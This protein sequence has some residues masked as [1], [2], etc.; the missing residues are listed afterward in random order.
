MSSS[1]LAR[2]IETFPVTRQTQRELCEV[3]VSEIASDEGSPILHN[4]AASQDN[5]L[6][7]AITELSDSDV[8]AFLCAAALGPSFWLSFFGVSLF[9]RLDDIFI[10]HNFCF[11]NHS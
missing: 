3:E 1:L 10:A 4:I 11:V 2:L 8:C 9:L 5:D 7:A 6:E